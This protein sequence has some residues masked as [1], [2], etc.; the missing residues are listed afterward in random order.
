LYLAKN[1]DVFVTTF[2]GSRTIAETARITF[3]FAKAEN[4][5][6]IE[7]NIDSTLPDFLQ[8]SGKIDFVFMDANHRYEPTLKYFNL[9]LHKT[10]PLSIIVVDDIHYSREME[11]AWNY[12]RHHSLVY[13]SVDIYRCGLLFL[14]PSLNKQHVV[15]QF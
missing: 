10:H 9:L 15:L 7:G 1:P 12:L 4:I 2:E 13:G 14:D 6:L 11:K 3:E 5:K 8:S